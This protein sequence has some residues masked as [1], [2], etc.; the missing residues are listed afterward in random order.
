MPLDLL[1]FGAVSFAIETSRLKKKTRF[2]LAQL[3]LPEKQDSEEFRAMKPEFRERLKEFYPVEDD[4]SF[5]SKLKRRTALCCFPLTGWHFYVSIKDTLTERLDEM[6][7]LALDRLDEDRQAALMKQ[8][9][10]F[11]EN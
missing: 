9:R 5:F 1:S 4:S 2:Y 3:G 7:K 6:E 11:S 10:P 8:V